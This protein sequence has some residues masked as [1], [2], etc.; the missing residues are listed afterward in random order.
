MLR[1]VGFLQE[2]YHADSKPALFGPKSQVLECKV[3]VF[4]ILNPVQRVGASKGVK[5][6]KVDKIRDDYPDMGRLGY[7]SHLYHL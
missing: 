3:K 5:D 1:K 7:N 4:K 2:T 6:C